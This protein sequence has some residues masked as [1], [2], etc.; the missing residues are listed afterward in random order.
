MHRDGVSGLYISDRW[1]MFPPDV[2][3]AEFIPNGSLICRGQQPVLFYSFLMEELVCACIFGKDP[4][5]YVLS[6]D[7]SRGF[8][9]NF[10]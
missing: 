1:G 5:D 10:R 4:F 3:F 9:F 6:W 8:S 2:H 7:I